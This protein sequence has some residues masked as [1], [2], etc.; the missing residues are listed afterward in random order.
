MHKFI[1]QSNVKH[2]M[3]SPIKTITD[4]I[5]NIPA[6]PIGIAEIFA[7]MSVLSFKIAV[8]LYIMLLKMWIFKSDFKNVV[9]PTLFSNMDKCIYNKI[10]L[11]LVTEILLTSCQTTVNQSIF[12][13]ATYVKWKDSYHLYSVLND[14][15]YNRKSK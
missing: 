10:S 1:G 12:I 7:I 15:C 9:S 14:D 13:H 8:I 11:V 2:I 6:G 3:T 5:T 4:I